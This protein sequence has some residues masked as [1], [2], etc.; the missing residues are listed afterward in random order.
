MNLGEC[1]KE[2]EKYWV[3]ELG[4]IMLAPPKYEDASADIFKA[5][6]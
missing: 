1:V 5:I 4:R 3:K 6:S 2:A